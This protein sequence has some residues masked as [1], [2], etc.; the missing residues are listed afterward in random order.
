MPLA[1]QKKPKKAPGDSAT[2]LRPLPAAALV[3]PNAFHGSEKSNPKTQS[4]EEARA[5]GFNR[6]DAQER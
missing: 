5:Q 3:T 1:K 6:Q 2:L 4:S